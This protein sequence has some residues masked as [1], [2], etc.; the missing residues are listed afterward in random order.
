MQ[1]SI[2]FIKM[3]IISENEMRHC[4]WGGRFALPKNSFAPIV[5]Q[6]A[7]I[8]NKTNSAILFPDLIVM[9]GDNLVSLTSNVFLSYIGQL[10]R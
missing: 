1:F 2:V 5:E 9:F 6:N 4:G 10:L 7:L 8:V 3:S